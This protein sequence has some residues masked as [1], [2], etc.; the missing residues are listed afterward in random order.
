VAVPVRDGAG[1]VVAALSA[2]LPNDGSAYQ[3]IPLLLT[4]ARGIG[5]RL[6]PAAPE[7]T[8]GTALSMVESA[9][10]RR[11]RRCGRSREQ[12]REVGQ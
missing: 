1:D 7:V 5:R 2:V 8:A 10:A 4:A 3:Q 6:V 11:R 9:L 12:A